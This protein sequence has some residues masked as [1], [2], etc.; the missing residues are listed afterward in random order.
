L[1]PRPWQSIDEAKSPKPSSVS[2]AAS[3]NGETKNALAACARWCS[4]LWTSARRSSVATPSASATC[5]LTSRTFVAL[6]K[7]SIT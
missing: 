1:L 2:T 5:V 3:S 4:T 7:R 6:R